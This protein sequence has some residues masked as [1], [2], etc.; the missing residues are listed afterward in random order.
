VDCLLDDRAYELKI[1]VTIAASGQGRWQEE[2]DFPIDCRK[3]GFKPIL[4]CMDSTANPKLEALARAFIKQKG[5]VYVG[6]AAWDHL[7]AL[8]GETMSKFLEH[9]VRGPIQSVLEDA[10]D[11]LLDICA[12]WHEEAIEIEIGDEVLH[13][14]R[15]GEIVDDAEEDEMP[16][17]ADDLVPGS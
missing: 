11:T 8:A 10:G 6:Q 4:V 16:T 13:I 7:E 14:D 3:S 12:H 1:R 2:L 17:D 9:Y 15:L 5:E